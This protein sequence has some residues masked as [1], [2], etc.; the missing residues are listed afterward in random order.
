MMQDNSH[1]SGRNSDTL[2]DWCGAN[3]GTDRLP[4][5]TT[6]LRVDPPGSVPESGGGFICSDDYPM[7]T[8][9]TRAEKIRCSDQFSV[10][11]A[12]CI[13]MHTDK[14]ALMET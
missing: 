9:H 4:S 8:A 2:W 7:S 3:P 5:E 10:Q 12:S 1:P 6:S 11:Y 13:G 14:D